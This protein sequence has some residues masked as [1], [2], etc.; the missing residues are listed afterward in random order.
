MNK[1]RKGIVL[2]TTMLLLS[3]IIM[4]SS[5]LIVTGRNTMLLG[6]SYNERERA[7]YAA[8][9]GI[10]YVQFC[11]QRYKD[12]ISGETTLSGVYNPD[13]S[14]LTVATVNSQ[15]RCIRGV[16][17]DGDSEFYVVFYNGGSWDTGNDKRNDKEGNALRFYSCNNL[18]NEGD[19]ST[20]DLSSNKTFRTVPK[21]TAH[22]IVEGRCGSVKRYVE[23]MLKYDDTPTGGACTIAAGGVDIELTDTDSFFMVNT[24]NGSE[25]RIR[26]LGDIKISSGNSNDKNCFQIAN[27]GRSCTGA[28]T[29]GSTVEKH[30]YV[31]ETEIGDSNQEDYGITCD[32]STQAPYFDNA[33]LTWKDVTKKYFS[34]SEGTTYSEDVKATIRPGTYIYKNTSTAPDTYTLYYYPK[35]LDPD[36][37]GDFVNENTGQ[38]YDP[39][40]IDGDSSSFS[41]KSTATSSDFTTSGSYLFTLNKPVGISADL[42]GD[43]TNNSFAIS[44][45]DYNSDGDDYIPSTKYRASL[46]LNGDSDPSIITKTGSDVYVNGELSGKGKVLCGGDLQFQG[47]SIIDSDTDSGLSLYTQGTVTVNPVQGSGGSSDP[48]EAIKTAW[49]AYASNFTESNGYYTTDKTDYTKVRDAILNTKIDYGG[50]SDKKLIDVLTSLSFSYDKATAQEL[51]S[52]MLSKNSVLGQETGSTETISHDATA[53]GSQ[54]ATTIGDYKVYVAREDGGQTTEHRHIYIYDNNG[55]RKANYKIKKDGTYE[56]HQN[57][58]GITGVSASLSGYNGTFNLTIG[59]TPLTFN[60]NASGST[61]WSCSYQKTGTS[62]NATTIKLLDKDSD[63]FKNLLFSDT[64][65]KGLV[66]TWGNLSGPNLQGGSFNIRGAVMAY[67]GNPSTQ[68]PGANGLGKISLKNGKN[69]TFTYDPSYMHMIIDSFNGINTKRIFS[70]SF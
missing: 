66:Y 60:I 27:S 23:A 4:I 10:A 5:L 53:F 40:L 46:R 28:G 68:D 45:Y 32:N 56:T 37:A 30:T 38:A 69:V 12:W 47:R 9:S 21:Q 64:I 34:D 20:Y 58:I 26:S 67:G 3:V 18:T 16:I 51:I 55:N 8:E 17:N 41:I 13:F 70:S 61:K 19:V 29:E 36:S 44:V 15:T 42:Y 54:K 35:V 43:E 33:K 49:E 48:N 14:G 39:S 6:T 52:S 7:Y 22:I 50:H 59:E 63:K 31:N 11:F 65:L 62:T 25:S 2:I 1:H 57:D 24:S